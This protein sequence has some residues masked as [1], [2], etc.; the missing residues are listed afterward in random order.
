MSAATHILTG[1][2]ASSQRTSFS[3]DHSEIPS[4]PRSHKHAS[5]SDEPIPL[6]DSRL[7]APQPTAIP[8]APRD[9]DAPPPL[10]GDLPATRPDA[11]HLQARPDTAS[12]IASF[13]SASADIPGRPSIASVNSSRHTSPRKPPARIG[14]SFEALLASDETYVFKETAK[15][16]LGPEDSPRASSSRIPSSHSLDASSGSKRV[17]VE[18][19][20]ES[21]SSSLLSTDL[22]DVHEEMTDVTPRPP[23]ADVFASPQQQQQHQ[24]QPSTSSATILRSASGGVRADQARVPASPDRTT[25]LGRRTAASPSQPAKPRTSNAMAT[26][27]NSMLPPAAPASPNATMRARSRASSSLGLEQEIHAATTDA[28]AE[29][30]S[31]MGSFRQRM[32]KTSGFLRKLRK[33]GTQPRRDRDANQPN[34]AGS[35]SGA[36]S[37]GSNPSATSLGRRE[38]KAS[39]HSQGGSSTAGSTSHS[40]SHKH[41]THFASTDG[42]AVPDI[43]ERFM[44]SSA[45]SNSHMSTIPSHATMSAQDHGRTLAADA[46]ELASPSKSGLRVPSAPATMTE[47]SPASKVALPQRSSSQGHERNKSLASSDSTGA[48]RLAVQQLESQM[49]DALKEAPQQIP[50]AANKQPDTQSKK[51]WGP[52]PQLPD[53][54]IQRYKERSGSFLEEDDLVSVDTNAPAALASANHSTSSHKTSTPTDA[55]SPAARTAGLPVTTTGLGISAGASTEEAVVSSA[56]VQNANGVSVESKASSKEPVENETTKRADRPKPLPPVASPRVVDAPS[57]TNGADSPREL[58]HSARSSVRNSIDPN[59]D[60]QLRRRTMDSGASLVSARSFETAAETSAL[61]SADTKVTSLSQ[62]SHEHQA[63]GESARVNDTP[64]QQPLA[65]ATAGSLDGTEPKQSH[66]DHS[67]R[68]ISNGSDLEDDDANELSVRLVTKRSDLS[69]VDLPSPQEIGHTAIITAPASPELDA[70]ALPKVVELSQT[71]FLRPG[72]NGSMSRGHSASSGSVRAGP[73]L[74]STPSMRRSASPSSSPTSARTSFEAPSSRM[75][76]D[77]MAAPPSVA[78]SAH[79]LATKCW[80][81][82]ASFLKREKIAEWLGGLGLINRAARTFYFANFDFSTLRLD[83]AFRRLCD[84]LFLR[85]ETQQIDRIL[86]AF[87]QRYFECNPDSIFGSSDVIHSVVFSI[88]LLNTDLHIAELQERMTRQQF[89]R[90]TL[91]AIAESSSDA[92]VSSGMDDSRSSFSTAHVDMTRS[93]DAA[94]HSTTPAQRRNSISSYLGSRSKHSLAHLEASSDSQ[95]QDTSRP[96]TAMSGAKGKEADIEAMLRDI[97]AAVKSDRILLPSPEG[98][99]GTLATGRTSGTFSPMGGSRRKTGKGNDR[100]TALKRGSIRGIQGLLGGMNSNNSFL[101]PA[102]SPNPS[103]SSVDSWG[104]SSATF[105]SGVDRDRLLSPALSVTPGF[106]STLSHT[107]IKE[108]MEED[109]VGGAANASSTAENAID[110]E[111]DDD[112][113]ALAGPPW[114]K[115]GSLTRKHYWESTGKRAKDKNWTE[116][117]VVVSKGTLSMFRFDT[118]GSSASASTASKAKGRASAAAAVGGDGGASAV[119]GGGNWLS[120]A[121]CLGEIPL[122]HSLANALPPPGYNRTRPHVFA[123]TLPGG[124]VYFFQTGHEELVNEWVSTCNYWA[125]RQSKEP[126]AGGV[127][128]M[129]YGWNK[130][131]PQLDDDEYEELDN[132]GASTLGS[133]SQLGEGDAR[134][135]RSGKGGVRGKVGLRTFGSSSMSPSPATSISTSSNAG[136]LS[137]ERVFVNEWRAPQL[138]TV[139][140]TLSEERQLARLEKQVE[141]LEAELTL[142]NELR[143]PMLSLYSPKGTNHAKALANWE[144]KSNHLLQELVK[145]HSYTEAL[146]K[147]ADL[148]AERTARREVEGMIQQGD[149]A[150]AELSIA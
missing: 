125:A 137:N 21:F 49:E 27:P 92:P 135:V 82:D 134:S 132:G 50:N 131:L 142:H 32:K 60:A 143:Q 3:S 115:E 58:T 96:G 70:S 59:A 91:S 112:K 104:R 141:R 1:D 31:S 25:S 87:S 20:R 45:S 99:S 8:S 68:D 90:N 113:L 106:A 129:E 65:S 124:K 78:A 107:I 148:K 51:Q 140:S 46:Q 139:A 6:P 138:P 86:A 47:W 37:T 48:I 94:A 66:L 144:R 56:A 127:S 35:S 116:L 54:D 75:A 23:D 88:L 149:D 146:R 73:G 11:R 29:R 42:V 89:V 28:D 122:A 41:T 34:G 14:R 71:S 147:S 67:S 101:D 5:P 110:E 7:D 69:N 24:L 105:A 84:K 57:S 72:R 22:D 123:L 83:V 38:S 39:V 2:N 19:R 33:D 43:P 126:L 145:Y 16:A 118:G 26:Q 133:Q 119:L 30:A 15:V 40:T 102:V 108:S 103:R 63:S 136:Y 79:E 98:G 13:A 93:A 55:R 12:T 36:Y 111:D 74:L 9:R 100:M 80:E 77:E 114:A 44:Q 64:T 76:K 97:Y 53:L 18:R 62:A 52:S 4:Y 95:P 121:T 81:E 17:I 85:A 117:F 128:N 130:V 109:A 61:D 150:L 120:N 10:R